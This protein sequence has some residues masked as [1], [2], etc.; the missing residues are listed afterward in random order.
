MVISIIGLLSTVVLAS[1]NT[2]R[3]KARDAKRIATLKEIQKALELYYFDHNGE[4]PGLS[5]GQYYY[6]NSGPETPNDCGNDVSWAIPPGGGWCK[7]ENAILPYLSPLTRDSI[8]GSTQYRFYYKY[9]YPYNIPSPNS[10]GLGVKLENSS[11]IS[12]NDGGYD[13]TMFE[14]G[15]LPSYCK[16]KYS[17]SDGNWNYWIS[18]SVCVGGD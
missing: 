9:V 4:Y 8:T 17:G 6:A 12:Q 11:S 7:L 13:A 18:T 1:L 14:I 10:Y 2:A 5:S 15:N 16:T 3:S